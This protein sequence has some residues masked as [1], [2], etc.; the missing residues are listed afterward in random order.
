FLPDGARYLLVIPK[1][2]RGTVLAIFHYHPRAG[3]LGAF[4]TYARL[5][6]RYFWPGIYRTTERYGQSCVPCQH[7]KTWRH[8]S[9]GQFMPLPFSEM[10]FH[11]V[12]IDLYGVLPK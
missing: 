3:H 9:G 11:R 7:R 4:K 5:W 10:P 12:G 6:T 8:A 2:L 1:Q